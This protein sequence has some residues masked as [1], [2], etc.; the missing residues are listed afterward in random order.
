MVGGRA[1]DVRW[2]HLERGTAENGPLTNNIVERAHSNRSVCGIRRHEHT[3]L[4]R[5]LRGPG[6]RCRGRV[7]GESHG[8]P[9][10]ARGGA[11]AHEEV[12]P[13]D[14]HHHP[15]KS[16]TWRDERDRWG[17]APRVR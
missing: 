4:L 16:S 2:W 12:G 5:S 11:G 3:E 17:T 15:R 14:R 9:D 7:P 13:E 6:M 1:G 8:A 10:G